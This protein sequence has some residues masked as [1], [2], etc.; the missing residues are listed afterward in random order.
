MSDKYILDANN[1]CVP[2]DLITWARWF[3]DNDERRIVAKSMV[4]D[5]EVSTVF[6]G[7]DHSYMR[8]PRQVFET[9]IFGGQYDGWQDRYATWD[10]ATA[11]HAAAVEMLATP[12]DVGRAR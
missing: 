10:Q 2:A 8:G 6:L 5:A 1:V 9:M 11:G 12:P 7:L 3:E 4:G